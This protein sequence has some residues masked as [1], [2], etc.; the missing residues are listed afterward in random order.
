MQKAEPFSAELN[1][2]SA[3]PGDVAAW[4]VEAGD[5]TILHRIAA[6]H[7]ND[8]DRCCRALGGTHR[9]RAERRDNDSDATPD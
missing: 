8:R 6:G 5:E 4:S 3:Q 1:A 2:H 9:C 7:E